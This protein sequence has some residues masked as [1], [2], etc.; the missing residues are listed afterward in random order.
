MITAASCTN[1]VLLGFGIVEQCTKHDT[2]SDLL[3]SGTAEAGL[4]GANISLLMLDLM[5]L[6]SSA[7]D[8]PQQQLSCD[9]T[10]LYPNDK[11]DIKKPLLYFLQ[12]SALTSKITVHLDG[13]ITFMG[14]EI[15]MKDLLSVVA[16]SYLS[17]S[18]HMGEKHSML[19][20]QFRRYKYVQMLNHFNL[21]VDG[22]ISINHN[23]IIRF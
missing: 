20:P 5:K 6:Q 9:S 15:Q 13:Q 22:W 1:A 19:V 14:T 18:L 16:K 10:L 17:K 21:Y 4:D 3:K 23:I 8:E 12:D 11:F 2:I 7:I